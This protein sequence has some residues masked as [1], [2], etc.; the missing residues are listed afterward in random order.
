MHVNTKY[1]LKHHL[2][3]PTNQVFAAREDSSGGRVPVQN[4]SGCKSVYQHRCH[5]L[6]A[7]SQ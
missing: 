4:R 7:E 6:D 5:L 1:S 2:F 3:H